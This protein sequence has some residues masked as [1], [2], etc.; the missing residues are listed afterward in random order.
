[1]ISEIE[2][3]DATNG[4]RTLTRD[5]YL[6]E[7]GAAAEVELLEMEERPSATR[8]IPEADQVFAEKMQDQQDTNTA[9]TAAGV[10]AL[11]ELPHESDD[12]AATLPDD[13]PS[14]REYDYEGA[15]ADLNARGS[16]PDI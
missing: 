4:L 10:A 12:D 14:P 9:L 13:W 11:D 1:M 3:W 6:A 8:S 5:E 7:F 16:L 15:L 2:V